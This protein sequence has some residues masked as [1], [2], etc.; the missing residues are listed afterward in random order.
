MPIILPTRARPDNIKRFLDIGKPIEPVYL[1]LD[2][3][4]PKLK[5]YEQIEGVS[6][7]ISHNEKKGIGYLMNKAFE[8]MPNE[9]Y[10][11]IFADD[12][13]PETPG[14][15]I[16]LKNACKNGIAWGADGI[17]NDRLPTHCFIDG[18]IVRKLGFIAHPALKHCFIDDCWKL[19]YDV[20]GG[21]YLPD[22]IIT[23]HHY[24]NGKAI[25]DETYAN[26]PPLEE[27]QKVFAEIAHDY[28]LKLLQI[29]GN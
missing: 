21:K 19:V 13:V 27:D 12:C 24:I 15:D 8:L 14:W 17:Q 6:F 5:E 25:K 23:H 2:D 10:Y 28:I 29:K 16:K 18:G 22:I 7:I 9:P 4:D 20:I 3:D 1:L 11:A 26:Q